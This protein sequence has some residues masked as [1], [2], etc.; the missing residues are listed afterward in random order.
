MNISRHI[1]LDAGNFLSKSLRKNPVLQVLLLLYSLLWGA[2]MLIKGL[3]KPLSTAANQELKYI[4][5][6]SGVT[7]LLFGASVL[8]IYAAMSKKRY[9]GIWRI[10]VHISL[11]ASMALDF[12]CFFLLL[13]KALYT[14]KVQPSN[15]I[16]TLFFYALVLFCLTRLAACGLIMT[17]LR[18]NTIR[19]KSEGLLKLFTAP[20]I[21]SCLFLAI[22]FVIAAIKGITTPDF[23]LTRDLSGWLSLGAASLVFTGFW[24]LCIKI[25][26][27]IARIFA[28]I[29]E[30]ISELPQAEAQPAPTVAAS[31]AVAFREIQDEDGW[32]DISENA[33]LEEDK[34]EKQRH[35]SSQ[36]D[37]A[38]FV[39]GSPEAVGHSAGK[40]SLYLS[41]Y[42]VLFFGSLKYF[43]AMLGLKIN[44]A[45]RT[46]KARLQKVKDVRQSSIDRYNELKARAKGIEV[47]ISAADD[48]EEEP[49]ESIEEDEEI[50]EQA[51]P[52][53][54]EWEIQTEKERQ[55]PNERAPFLLDIIEYESAEDEEEEPVF[56]P[57]AEDEYEEPIEDE[58]EEKPEEETELEP[59]EELE[60]EKPAEELE[61]E[62]PEPD[63][64]TV[65]LYVPI[66]E[67][68]QTEE[69]PIVTGTPYP[70]AQNENEPEAEAE[71]ET[72]AEAEESESVDIAEID[73]P[74][75]EIKLPEPELAEEAA[76]EEESE[77]DA[78]VEE[79]A[80][81]P[82]AE[83]LQ[84]PEEP[85]LI[86]LNAFVTPKK[87]LRFGDYDNEEVFD[88]EPEEE[89]ED[90][91]GIDWEPAPAPPPEPE[92]ELPPKPELEI[93]I[94][95]EPQLQPKPELELELEPEPKPKPKPQAKPKTK[96]VRGPVANQGQQ[97]GFVD[98]NAMV[99]V[100]K[101]KRIRFEDE[102]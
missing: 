89:I 3:S 67:A 55:E 90:D 47:H 101:T 98:L 22:T 29:E 58:P 70:I 38:E 57:D 23:I 49:E 68:A 5:I 45:G 4:L 79:E 46:P 9:S 95:P 39:K 61:L 72:E 35:T 13:Y 36:E 102:D 27:R 15:L 62:I 2:G 19:S 76:Q 12:G 56:E 28:E 88:N 32:G 82:E 92:L 34:P 60:P 8:V 7:A 73:E 66:E 80:E 42:A 21:L 50:Q 44:F 54:G 83:E 69:L 84:F 48:E 26:G 20:G 25:S 75:E 52:A 10:F 94:E 71:E 65:E 1:K 99:E 64:P 17:F 11:F 31:A 86:D 53:T 33:V 63:E 30:A 14:G 97:E 37:L 41:A 43:F 100:K 87:T 85:E 91:G 81:D 40:L 16:L 78:P 59:Q 77:A 96:P 6:A 74:T 51:E 93:E 18:S 24:L